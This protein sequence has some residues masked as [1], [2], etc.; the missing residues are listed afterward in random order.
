MGGAGE[1]V[2][3]VDEVWGM[4]RLIRFFCQVFFVVL[5]FGTPT[6]AAP[7]QFGRWDCD[8]VFTKPNQKQQFA[9]VQIFISGP[10]YVSE[11]RNQAIFSTGSIRSKQLRMEAA[12]SL[13]VPN[14]S[15]QD[16]AANYST[17]FE[18]AGHGY[19][20]VVDRQAE[21]AKMLH[22]INARFV[23]FPI[24]SERDDQLQM[25]NWIGRCKGKSK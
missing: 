22:S 18:V 16:G 17:E 9:K 13:R 12:F 15:W 8:T 20:I 4:R 11:D 25:E 14:S 24:V 5:A 3:H 2:S 23:R 10:V 19:K 7:M 21:V 1:W 6:V